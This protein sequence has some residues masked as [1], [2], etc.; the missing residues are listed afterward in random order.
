M[1]GVWGGQGEELSFGLKEV[2]DNCSA[3][4]RVWPRLCLAG[5]K[6]Y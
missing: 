4:S 2:L 3:K 5:E 6:N 1:G